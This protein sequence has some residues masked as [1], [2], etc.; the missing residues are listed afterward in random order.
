MYI[1]KNPQAGLEAMPTSQETRSSTLGYN[2]IDSSSHGFHVVLGFQGDLQ[3][4]GAVDDLLEAGGGDGL[5]GDAVHLVEGVRLQDA[6]VRRA[7]E[8]LQAQRLLA[9]VAVQLP[10]SNEKYGV[11]WASGNSLGS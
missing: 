3:D 6:L 5:A 8:D 4:F 2:V 9:F 7:D 11:S 10:R 1:K